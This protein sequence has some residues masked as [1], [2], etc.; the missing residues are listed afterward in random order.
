MSTSTVFLILVSGLGVLHGFILAIFL[1]SSSKN[2]ITS[3][4]ILSLLL[5]VLSFRVGKSVLLE[6]VE[7]LNIQII[8]SGLATLMAIGPLYYLYTRSLIDKDFQFKNKYFLHYIPLLLGVL[9]GFWVNIELLNT[10]PKLVVILIFS[11]YYSHYLIYLICSYSYTLK[12]K[13]SGLDSNSFSLLKL[14][15]LGLLIIWVAYVLNLFDEIIPYII[16]PILYSLVAYIISIIIFKKGYLKKINHI[17]YQTTAIPIEQIDQL[18]LKIKELLIRHKQYK[19]GDLT[20]KSLSEQLHITPQ[21]L[22]LVVNTKNKTNFNN[23]I[24]H[25][26]IEEAITLFKSSEYKHYTIASISFESGFN[27]ISSFNTAFKKHTK[28]TPTNF[29]K[30]LS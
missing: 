18:F 2:N 13:N 21:T 28:S 29:R 24:N 9:F 5:I 12:R 25:Y 17:K 6:F 16:G 4:K 19:N 27:S 30:Q 3:N 7:H 26:R 15:F 11:S 14:V 23:F 20:L 10:L 8:F 22:S 1:W